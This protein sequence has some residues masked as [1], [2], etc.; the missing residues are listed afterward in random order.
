ME[1]SYIRSVAR[2]QPIAPTLCLKGDAIHII[3]GGIWPPENLTITDPAVLIAFSVI[4]QSW[5]SSFNR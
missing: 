5:I 3:H 4:V 2:K 1:F